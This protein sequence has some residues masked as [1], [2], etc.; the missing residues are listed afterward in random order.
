M[1]SYPRSGNTW[2]RALLLAYREGERFDLNRMDGIPGEPSPAYY[3]EL[4]AGEEEPNNLDWAHM[5]ALA[6]RYCYETRRHKEFVLKT[7]TANIKLADIH[8]IPRGYT[9]VAIYV[10]RDPRDVLCSCARYFSQ[11]HEKTLK[12]MLDP[13]H[14]LVDEKS[15][16]KQFVSSYANHVKG[17]TGEK[18]FPVHVVRY[19]DLVREPA[20]QLTNMLKFLNPDLLVDPDQVDAAVG[21][22]AIDA[23]RAVEKAQGFRERPLDAGQFFGEGREGVWRTTLAPALADELINR[24]EDANAA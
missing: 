13:R 22:C 15:G 24:L 21:R 19:G 2:V 17:W 10:V 16:T 14:V 18:T 7:H 1:A 5:R 11:T 3:R 23:F 12:L 9:N 20:V 8:L 4:W 6:L